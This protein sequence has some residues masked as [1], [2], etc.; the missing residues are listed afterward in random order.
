MYTVK[1]AAIVIPVSELVVICSHAS[2]IAR[3]VAIKICFP[4]LIAPAWVLCIEVQIP[5]DDRL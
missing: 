3:K 4:Y 5:G 2:I 1:C